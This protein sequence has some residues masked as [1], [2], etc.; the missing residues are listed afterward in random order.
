MWG[1]GNKR[2]EMWAAINRTR[3][4][5]GATNTALAA[6]LGECRE[7]N[8][9]V[10]NTLEA[11]GRA[12]EAHFKDTAEAI[13]KTN[14]KVEAI[15][16]RITRTTIAVLVSVLMGIIQVLGAIALLLLGKFA[17]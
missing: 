14:A 3:D 4:D 11:S 6:H 2:A 10:Q 5:L 13:A 1:N 12:R 17:H 7:A 8:R 9:A 15:D 16:R